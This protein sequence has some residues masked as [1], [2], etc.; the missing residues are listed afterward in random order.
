MSPCRKT[1]RGRF[2]IY[3]FCEICEIERK[4][5]FLHPKIE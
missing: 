2:Y 4:D 5:V 1:I 3:L